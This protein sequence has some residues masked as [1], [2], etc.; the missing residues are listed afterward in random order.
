MSIGGYMLTTADIDGMA[1]KS[2]ALLTQ[3]QRTRI[4]NDFDELTEDEKRRDQQRIR[5]RLQSG[6]LD[7]HLL[8]DYPDRQF[9]L[10]FDDVSDDE[11]RTAL[12]DSCLVVERLRELHGYDRDVLI[13]EVRLSANESSEATAGNT[14][15]DRIDL[16][17][18]TEIRR[19]TEA[20]VEDRLG[21]GRW[22]TRASRL[23]KLGVSAFIP[24]A[25]FVLYQLFVGNIPEFSLLNGLFAALYVLFSVCFFGWMLIMGA[26]AVKYDILPPIK[27][28]VGHPDE[29]WQ[30]VVEKLI[31]NP[32]KTVRESWN[33]L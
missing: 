3:T 2:A 19:Q 23:V 14:S 9:T 21:E 1:G 6:I 30:T 26:K 32:G 33:E 24:L 11:L 22:D 8:A 25:L 29:V 20:D 16:R 28:L 12:V 10:A 17:T 31:R 15:L 5:D 18:T 13:E 27:K 7:F 4:Q